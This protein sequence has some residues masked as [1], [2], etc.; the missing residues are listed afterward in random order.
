[1]AGY[2]PIPGSDAVK[3]TLTTS[4]FE[5]EA[6]KIENKTLEEDNNILRFQMEKETRYFERIMA[7][8]RAGRVPILS[9]TDETGEEIDGEE[10]QRLRDRK[11]DEDEDDDSIKKFFSRDDPVRRVMMHI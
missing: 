9:E 11:Y 7:D 6:E 5:N 1:M 3:Q 10:V 8:L 4:F 2:V